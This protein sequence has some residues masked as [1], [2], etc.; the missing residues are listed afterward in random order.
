MIKI[1][2]RTI[3]QYSCSNKWKKRGLLKSERNTKQEEVEEMI[4][5]KKYFKIFNDQKIKKNIY[6]K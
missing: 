3:C 2:S 4:K 6:S 1:L 5:K